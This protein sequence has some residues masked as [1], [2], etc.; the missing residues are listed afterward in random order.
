MTAHPGA[1]MV[2]TRASLIWTA[3]EWLRNNQTNLN[4]KTKFANVFGGNRAV[5]FAA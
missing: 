2:S 1:V 5:A 3:V 4:A